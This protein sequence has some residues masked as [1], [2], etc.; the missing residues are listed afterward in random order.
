MKRFALVLMALLLMC[1]S[2]VCIAET[3]PEAEV[4]TETDALEFIPGERLDIFEQDGINVYLTGEVVD[5]GLQFLRM[6]AII[7]NN[8]DKNIQVRYNG[9]ANGWSVKNSVMGG[10]DAMV[11]AGSKAKSYI[12]LLY[13]D[14][15]IANYNDLE[16][17]S[18]TF[19][20]EDSDDNSALFTLE[21]ISITF[22]RTRKG[23]YIL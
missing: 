18:L 22:G 13:D 10:G 21:P 17:L 7:E 12:W 19:T 4:G 20:V 5:E 1:N 8:S 6:E 9:V 23:N 15:D 14:L 3:A 16:T 11:N 2:L